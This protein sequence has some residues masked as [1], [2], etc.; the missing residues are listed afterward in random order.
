MEYTNLEKKFMSTKP[1][2]WPRNGR[3][4]K[5][6]LI[7]EK[8][9]EFELHPS[10]RS[11]ELLLA[12]VCDNDANQYSSFGEMRVTEF[13]AELINI[14]YF[15]AERLQINSIKIYLYDLI[16]ET[17]RL[18]KIMSWCNPVLGEEIGDAY[19]IKPYE[20]ILFLQMRLY[21]Y[22]Y[23]KYTIEKKADFASQLIEIIENS[24]NEVPQGEDIGGL[25]YAFF[26]LLT[27]MSYMRG[28][29][30]EK[31]WEFTRDDLYKLVSLEARLLK[32][33]GKNILQKPVKG[34]MKIQIS[35]Y[36]L[37]SRN[38]YNEDYICKYMSR[39]VAEASASNHEIWMK[40]IE[41]LNDVREQKVIPELF[42]DTAWIPYKWAKD[43]DFTPPRRYFV[44]SFSKTINNAVM[45]KNYGECIY[46][47]K[48]DRIVD[49]IG[50]IGMQKFFKK[51]DGV[52]P[53][54][55]INIP[56]VSQVIAFDVIYD[57]EEAK[58][59]LMYLLS[60]IDLFDLSDE[61]KHLF[62]E[63]L[64]QYW[65]LSVK[66]F[67][68]HKERERRYVIFMYNDYEYLETTIE[69]D[70]LKVGTSLFLLPDFIL[71]NNPVREEIRFQVENKQKALMSKEYFHCKNCLMQDYDVAVYKMPEVCPICGSKQI[72]MIYPE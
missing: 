55:V 46:G 29:A 17:T 10:Y 20:E 31:L 51:K 15:K 63:E 2:D 40:E 48:N 9:G 53:E 24:L 19:R 38:G 27:D 21:H 37:K 18:Q 5:L 49:L 67:K 58:S 23:Q 43:F 64:L 71:G 36:I 61:Q 50:P 26:A 41:K 45:Q 54:E 42:D 34:M 16:T 22:A 1:N 8:I 52:S 7:A 65:I 66:D 56:F 14:I 12:I 11:R 72:E 60:V 25:A 69:D 4:A 13:E 30:K 3:E 32:L 62:M 59:E 28:N 44:S 70:F 57:K 47:Y 68:W 35:N 6:E 33:W 39:N